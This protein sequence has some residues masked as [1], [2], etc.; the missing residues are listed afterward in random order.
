MQQPTPP[1]FKTGDEVIFV[2]S[3]KTQQGKTGTVT[4]PPEI[5]AGLWKMRVQCHDPTVKWI[6]RPCTDFKKV[7]RQQQQQQQQQVVVVQPSAPTFHVGDKVVLVSEK[8]RYRGATGTVRTA[9]VISAG[10][11]K[12]RVLADDPNINWSLRPCAEFRLT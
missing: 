1:P 4:T 7:R 12:M 2:G 3:N 6:L 5:S 10:V 9:P 11:W 8:S